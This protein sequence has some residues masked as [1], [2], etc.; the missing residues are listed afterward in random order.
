MLLDTLS[1]QTTKG[2]QSTLP[3]LVQVQPTLSWLR[4]RKR[5]APIQ[6]LFH[7][8]L[9]APHEEALHLQLQQK[10]ALG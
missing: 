10:R 2:T 8:T 1:L 7:D 9:A 4:H 3:D 6:S 5:P